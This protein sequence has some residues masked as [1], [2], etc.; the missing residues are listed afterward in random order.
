MSKSP[1]SDLPS[2]AF[3]RAGVAATPGPVAEDIYAKKW[4]IEQTWKIATAGSCFAQHIGRHLRA[5]DFAIMDVEPA[6]DA[7][8]DPLHMT[9][10]YGIYSGRYGN[11]Y[12]M[13][14]MLQ[15][16]REALREDPQRDIIWEK[17]GRF[18]DGLRPTIEPDGLP[19][20]ASVRDHRAQH[21]AKVRAMLIDM[22]ML[23]FTLG[24]TE[25]WIDNTTGTVFPIC[26]GTVTTD[27]DPTRHVFKN[28][29]Y[30]EILADFLALRDLLNAQ[31]SADRPLRILLT[32]SPVP[33]TATAADN[34]VQVATVYSKSVLRA[35]AGDLA[36]TYADIDYFP[37]YEII[38]SPW[39]GQNFYGPN[40]RSVTA[41]GVDCA[42]STFMT[43]HAGA[44]PALTPASVPE[45][46]LPT[47]DTLEEDPDMLIQCDEELLDAFGTQ[48][49]T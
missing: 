46:A 16:A 49:N 2:R 24:L 26:P 34:H 35:V 1:Y 48:A 7:L 27:F 44:A 40:K 31:R 5:A 3:W 23:I 29:T 42:M 18:Y 45:T 9:Y 8:P 41:E 33:L 11:V 38:T 37:S 21:L 20:A 12:T 4:P 10:G 28:F 43:N 13:R 32:V 30:P 17:K 25:A 39:S 15:L 22:D 19:D 36:D 47:D 14:Q 6:P